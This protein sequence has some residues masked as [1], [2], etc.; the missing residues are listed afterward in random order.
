M[1]RRVMSALKPS[2]GTTPRGY[3]RLIRCIDFLRWT[4]APLLLHSGITSQPA[5]QL[6]SVKLMFARTLVVACKSSDPV[7]LHQNLSPRRPACAGSVLFRHALLTEGRTGD[8]MTSIGRFAY[9]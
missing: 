2:K 3:A 4:V 8:F 9:A 1:A 5:L 7:D 6:V